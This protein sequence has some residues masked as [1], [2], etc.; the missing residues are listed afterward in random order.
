MTH[1][2]TTTKDQGSLIAIAL[3]GAGRRRCRWVYL[4]HLPAR[5]R[6]TGS[7]AQHRHR[8]REQSPVGHSLHHWRMC[9]G[10][11]HCR[12]AGAQ[13]L[14]A[15]VGQ[16]YPSCGSRAGGATPASA[17]SPDHHQVCRRTSLYRWRALRSAGKVRACR[18]APACAHLIG[19]IFRRNWPECRVLLAAGAGAGL[20][21]R[22]QRADCGCDFCAG[23]TGA[24]FRAADCDRGAWVRRPSLLPSRGFFSGH[25]LT[26]TCRTSRNRPP[27]CCRCFWSWAW[28]QAFSPSIYNVTLLG[29]LA[30]ADWMK[31][32][33]VELR[34][35]IV[36]M[37]VGAL[38]WYAPALVGGG[39]NLTQRTLARRRGV[40]CVADCVRNPVDTRRRSPTPR[41]RP[42]GCLRRCWCSVRRSGCLLAWVSRSLLPDVGLQPQGFALV[43]MAAF[44]TGV[45]RAPLTG[46]V[47]VTEMTANVTLLLPMLGACFVAM[48][49]PTLIG[50][51]PIYM[52]LREITLR[53]EPSAQLSIAI[54][55]PSVA[56]TLN[57]ASKGSGSTT[58][59]F[60]RL[61]HVDRALSVSAARYSKS[62]RDFRAAAPAPLPIISSSGLAHRK[63]THHIDQARWH[64]VRRDSLIRAT[65]ASDQIGDAEIA[66]A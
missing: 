1:R 58:R 3:A 30:L 22:I 56:S 2:R 40:A 48:L 64:R 47:L 5:A 46:I 52:S 4:C 62:C 23:R 13:V 11:G 38:A 37:A 55:G 43:G 36:G 60:N 59:G 17:V 12:V 50:N 53:R 27:L 39:D 45:V 54:S 34:A 14:A 26:F 41:G 8:R 65:C 21:N 35:A 19:K 25:R 10:G 44:F 15:G 57:C 29:T 7:A 18:W 66:H 49:V 51:A 28:S 6:A 63:H 16:R 61:Q 33:P 24:A 31:W 32:L 20:R 9:V 42:A